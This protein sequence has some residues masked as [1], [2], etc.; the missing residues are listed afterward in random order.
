MAKGLKQSALTVALGMCFV[1]GVQAQTNSA[2]AVTGRA[3][4]GDTINITNPATGFNRTI[5]V[6]SDGGYRF[7][8]LPTGQYQISRNGAAPRSVTVNVGS[9]ATV[10]FVSGDATTLDTVTVVG[11]GAINP[12]DVSSVESTTILTAEQI[13]KIPVARD[14]TSVA[15]LAPGTVRGDAAFGNLASF[16]GASVAEN[17]YYVNGFNITN[18][19]RSL[20]YSAIPFEAIAEQQTKTGGYGAEF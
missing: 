2:G 8:Q 12:I 11:S 10:D 6:G 4:S 14:T 1:G 5:T 3:A 13:N 20:N 9:A 18:S 19:F 16:G 15:L 7:S 17:Q